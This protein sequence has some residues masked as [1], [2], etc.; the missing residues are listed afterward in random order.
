MLAIFMLRSQSLLLL[1][2]IPLAD[3]RG[4]SRVADKIAVTA[5]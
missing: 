1:L 3:V 2:K 4:W 5:G